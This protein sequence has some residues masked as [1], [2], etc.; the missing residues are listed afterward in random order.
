MILGPVLP[1]K[2]EQKIVDSSHKAAEIGLGIWKR[3]LIL[4]MP[5]L[6][7]S[8][9]LNAFRKKTSPV[10]VVGRSFVLGILNYQCQSPNLL[11]HW[12]PEC[13]IEWWCPTIS[14]NYWSWFPTTVSQLT[15]SG[16]WRKLGSR[17][18]I[19][20]PVVVRKG[21]KSS[22]TLKGGLSLI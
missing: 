20:R 19:G 15:L 9:G 6:C 22:K 18:T 12:G 3:Q 17:L 21:F 4:K 14:R 11:Q 2:G 16:T 7:N 13:W 1:M 8:L 10:M 5:M